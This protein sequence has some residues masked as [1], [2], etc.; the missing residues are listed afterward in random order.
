M[1]VCVRRDKIFKL[2][3]ILTVTKWVRMNLVGLADKH[4]LI[5]DK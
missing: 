3:Y 4:C 2:T 1:R 5:I